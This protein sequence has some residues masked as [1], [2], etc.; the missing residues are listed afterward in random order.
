V[1]FVPFVAEIIPWDYSEVSISYTECG[2]PTASPVVLEARRDCPSVNFAEVVEKKI[3]SSRIFS[4][5]PPHSM[6]V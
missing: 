6:V 4:D 3:P 5:E 2:A 1:F